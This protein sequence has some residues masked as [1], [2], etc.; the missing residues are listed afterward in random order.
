MSILDE[1]GKTIICYG[2]DGRSLRYED[3]ALLNYRRKDVWD[4]HIQELIELI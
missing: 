2:T 4:L 3:T 1:D